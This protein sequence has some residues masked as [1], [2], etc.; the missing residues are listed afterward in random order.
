M[1]LLKNQS[2]FMPISLKSVQRFGRARVT[3]IN[4][5]SHYNISIK[6]II[7]AD[8]TLYKYVLS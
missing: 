6:K 4:L 7:F 1:S 8:S 2:I 5:L 3:D